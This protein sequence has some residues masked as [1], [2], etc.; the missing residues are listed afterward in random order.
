LGK[1]DGP[2]VH[3]YAR[4]ASETPLYFENIG[5]AIGARFGLAHH[6]GGRCH[7]FRLAF[8]LRIATGS[9]D[10]VAIGARPFLAYTAFPLS[11]QVAAAIGVGARAYELETLSLYAFATIRNWDTGIQSPANMVPARADFVH[12]LPD[13]VKFAFQLVIPVFQMA[14]LIV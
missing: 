5:V 1:S 3:E 14:V 6:E 2:I 13:T 8:V 12:F 4:I 11:A 10:F 9:F 7:V